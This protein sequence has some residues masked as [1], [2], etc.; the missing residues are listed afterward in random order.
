MD[1]LDFLFGLKGVAVRTGLRLFHNIPPVGSGWIFY[2]KD[3][4]TGRKSD[5]CVWL[6]KRETP[7]EFF[8]RLLQFGEEFKKSLKEV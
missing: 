3:D 2:F 4:E 5:Y 1:Y 8:D 6:E 7:D